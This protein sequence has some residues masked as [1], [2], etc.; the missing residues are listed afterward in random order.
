MTFVVGL[1]GGI[2]SGKSTVADLFAEKGIELID[3]DIIARNVVALGSVGLSKVSEHFGHDV[4][5]ED[6]SL[7]RA[8]LREHIF[9]TPSDKQWLENLLHPMIREEMLRRIQQAQSP[10]CL[11][12]VPLLI[13]NKLESLCD[14]VLVVDVSP[15]T[16]IE[17]TT[18]RDNVT[19]KQV[20]RILAAQA[21]RE[22]RLAKADDIIDNDA[23][24]DNLLSQ[25]EKLH[26]FYLK[27]ATI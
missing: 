15:E 20:Q 6:G 11:L 3:A 17:R 16:Q 14:R 12:V 25:V 7:N 21:R 1:T 10:Y 2:G 18:Q 8:K 19:M 9:N 27:S 23:S 4:L 13:E 22:T 24:A 26:L 5:L